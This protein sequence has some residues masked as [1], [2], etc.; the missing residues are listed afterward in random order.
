MRPTGELHLGPLFGTSPGGPTYLDGPFLDAAG[1]KAYRQSLLDAYDAIHACAGAG[2]C[3][4][5]GRIVRAE[6][7]IMNAVADIETLALG[8]GESF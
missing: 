1:R 5:G 8:K 7:C 4:D 2:S 3:Y 6:K